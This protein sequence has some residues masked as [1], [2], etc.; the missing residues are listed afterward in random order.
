M[1]TELVTTGLYLIRGGGANSLLRFSANGLLLVD[2]KAPGNYKALMSQVRK[3]S[4]LLDMPVT[5]SRSTAGAT[6]P[7]AARCS[8]VPRS[9]PTGRSWGR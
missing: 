6:W 1:S 9:S 2:A 3:T 5:C 8:N 7:A 4:K